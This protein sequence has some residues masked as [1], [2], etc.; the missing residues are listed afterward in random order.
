[1]N[2]IETVTIPHANLSYEDRRH[3]SFYKDFDWSKS[4]KEDAVHF[5]RCTGFKETGM[6]VNEIALLY[7][8]LEKRRPRKI[9]ELGRNFGCS[10]RIF[11]QYVLRHGGV[12][13]SW[14]LKHWDGFIEGMAENGYVFVPVPE[15]EDFVMLPKEGEADCP[16]NIRVAHS[17]KTPVPYDEKVDFLL[18]DTEHGLEHALGE[19]MRWREYLNSGCMIAF[20]DSTLP[21]PARAIEI[22][23]E[24]ESAG[25]R[26]RIIREYVNERVDGYGIQVLEWKG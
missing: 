20:H 13:S 7:D 10:T 4:T 16:V 22:V 21:G 25:D 2:T 18:I 23:K 1:M 3:I 8:L 15:T 9:V 26:H 5:A 6:S 11:L 12:L 17:I 19:Y 14:D 24:V